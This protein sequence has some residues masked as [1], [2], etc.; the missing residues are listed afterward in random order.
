MHRVVHA[1]DYRLTEP[2]LFA[3]HSR[4]YR[5]AALIDHRCGSV[6]T[7]LT[8]N[9]LDS[10]GQIAPHMHSF[11]E[12]VYLLDGQVTLQLDDRTW[13]LAAGDYAVAK[14]GVVHAWHNAGETPARW[15]G[16]AAPQPRP[17]GHERDT[18]FAAATWGPASGNTWGPPSGGPAAS[19]GP[20]ASGGP[21]AL[22]GHFSAAD[23]GT[24]ENMA[25]AAAKGVFLRW[26]IDEP[27]G[28]RHHRLVF[29]EY[30]PDVGIALHDHTFEEAYFILSGTIEA[31]LDGEQYVAGPGDVLWTGVGCIHA[32]RNTSREP[33]RWIETFSPQPPAENVFRFVD[34]WRT[35]GRALEG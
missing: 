23:V 2:T 28:A 30:Q 34:E 17:D 26:L 31:T 20:A 33:V 11:E 25:P 35:K 16:M 4:G 22:V 21:G 13:T 9:S 3:G 32:F 18:F 19:A 12:G 6:H 10:G 24:A 15:I 8:L 5:S 29:I 27:F 14:V 7:G 1:K